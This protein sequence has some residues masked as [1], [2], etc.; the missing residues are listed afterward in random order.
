MAEADLEALELAELEQKID[1]HRASL[2]D[3]QRAETLRKELG[4]AARSV[5]TKSSEDSPSAGSKTYAFL[6][7]SSVSSRSQDCHQ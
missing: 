2:N 1:G 3:V 5:V 7:G 4:D 6:F